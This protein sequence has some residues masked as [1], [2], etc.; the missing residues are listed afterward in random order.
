MN[1]E[2]NDNNDD[3]NASLRDLAS[4]SAAHTDNV[5]EAQL[6]ELKRCTTVQLESLRPMIGD[7]ER[8]DKLIAAVAEATAKNES[9]GQ[10]KDRLGKEGGGLLK[11]GLTAVRMLK[12]F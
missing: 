7:Q 10:L 5:L 1:Q 12:G 6:L 4:Q 3:F 2:N 11:M 9:I 8:Y